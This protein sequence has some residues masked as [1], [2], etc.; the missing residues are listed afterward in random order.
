MLGV[1]GTVGEQGQDDVVECC[2]CIG[3]DDVLK[4]FK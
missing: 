4:C 1:G 2:R 3:L